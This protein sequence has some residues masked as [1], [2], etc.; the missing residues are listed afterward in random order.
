FDDGPDEHTIELATY[1]HEEGI[2]VTFF[3]NGRRI[4]KTEDAQGNCVAPMDTRP[5]DDGQSQAPVAAPKYYRE[6]ILDDVIRLGHRI[7]NHTEDH[8][9]LKAQTNTDDLVFELATTQAIVDR[10][11]CDGVFLFRPPYGDWDSATTTRARTAMSL[12]KL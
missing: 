9:H 1:L 7:A 5:C 8:C 6:S 2:R 11:V 12:D 3:I 4:C 10:H